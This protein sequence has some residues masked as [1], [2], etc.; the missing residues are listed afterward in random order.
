MRQ[1]S[2]THYLPVS[3][4][5]QWFVLV[6]HKQHRVVVILSPL[7]RTVA[8]MVLPQV[9]IHMLLLAQVLGQAQAPMLILLY[10]WQN[11]LS[12]FPILCKY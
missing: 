6:R 10:R 2:Q 11:S 12:I 4:S 5:V 7:D 9:D 8:D 3:G 1:V